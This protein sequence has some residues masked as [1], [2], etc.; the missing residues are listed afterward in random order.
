MK[1]TVQL[2]LVAALAL[3]L[4][5]NGMTALAEDSSATETSS[6]VT[7]ETKDGETEKKPDAKEAEQQESGH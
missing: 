4:S 7:V 6:A 1:K 3:S 5:L 2:L